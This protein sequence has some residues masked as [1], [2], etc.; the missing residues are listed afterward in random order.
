MH[1]DYEGKSRRK[2][3]DRQ[4]GGLSEC[5]I[6]KGEPQETPYPRLKDKRGTRGEEAGREERNKGGK[7]ER[8]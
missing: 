3:L 2:G 7:A 6:S 4:K 5:G 8:M 1:R